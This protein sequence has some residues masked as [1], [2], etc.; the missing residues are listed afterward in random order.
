MINVIVDEELYDKDFVE[1]WCY[2]FDKLAERVKE[3][4]PEKVA[5]ITWVPAEK[6]RE[7]ARLYA[8]SKPA[9][10][11]NGMGL[12]E[13]PN[14][15]QGI[16]ARFLLPALT[17]NLDVIGGERFMGHDPSTA[18]RIGELELR[19]KLSPEQ[20]RKMMGSERFKLFS[21]EAY[22]L[23][24]ES[25]KKIREAPIPNFWFSAVANAPLTFRAMI[26]GKPYPVKALIT[27]SENPLAAYG[28]TKLV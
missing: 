14:H 19:E 7:A 20:R 4:S 6:I 11:F 5:E 10:I 3:Y 15:M 9:A 23:I 22:D 16:W 1:K 24:S 18:P 26:E 28:D 12:E 25:V 17:G 8:A 13:L 21:W 2:G 27:E